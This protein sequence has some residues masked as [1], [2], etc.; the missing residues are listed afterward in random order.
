[1]PIAVFTTHFETDGRIVK[2]VDD[3]SYCLDTGETLGVVGE[4]GCGK[5]VS[6]LSLLRLIKDPPGRIVQGEIMFE[7]KD[8]LALSEEEIR[9]VRGNRIAMIFQEPMTSLN[10]VHTIGFQVMEPLMIHK[11]LSRSDA[12]RECIELL[13]T[14][15]IPDA[16]IRAR[17]YPHQFS[18]GM[19][20]RVMIAMG[21]ACAPRLII[22]DEPTTALDVTIQAELLELMK[23]LT[24]VK[25]TALIIIT[26]NLGVVARYADKVMVMYAGRIVEKADTRDLFRAPGHPYTRALLESVPR[27]DQDLKVKLRPIEG[28]PPDLAMLPS[29]CAFHPR[30][31][32]CMDRCRHEA[33]ALKN[34]AERHEVACWIHD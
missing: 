25:G 12:M 5:T 7:G 11:G 10:P 28:Q 31:P 22:A 29:G 24:V 32:Q 9:A 17:A 18:G 14:V 27:L 16:D 15:Q 6:A 23:R 4:S 1:M 20:Q 3:I 30:C 26:H 33:P 8:L 19:R 2:A 34:V 21:L 13:K